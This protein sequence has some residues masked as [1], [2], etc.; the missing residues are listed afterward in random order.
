MAESTEA[1]VLPDADNRQ[2]GAG[3]YRVDQ[4]GLE[5]PAGDLHSGVLQQIRRGHGRGGAASH[6][7]VQVPLLQTGYFR[8]GIAQRA[9]GCFSGNNGEHKPHHGQAEQIVNLDEGIEEKATS[10]YVAYR[11]AKNP[12]ESPS[13]RMAC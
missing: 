2:A 6:R 12:A 10:L 3:R 5:Q 13:S 4:A 7:A 11:A 9:G 8:A 1:L